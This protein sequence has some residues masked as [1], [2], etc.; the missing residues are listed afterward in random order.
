MSNVKEKF[1]GVFLVDGKLATRATF[2]DFR[3]FGELVVGDY[4]LWDPNR[5]K[6][7][8]AIMKGLKQMPIFP[9]A[10]VLYL[11]LAHAFSA[12]YVAD[13]VGKQGIIYGVEFS[14]RPF[15]EAL[16]I[17]EKYGNIVAIKADA[18]KTELFSWIEKV[19]VVFCD[20]ADTQMTE[21][22]AR[23]CRAFLKPDGFLMLAIKARSID[24]TAPP[25]QIVDAEV[26]K[27]RKEGFDILQV[28][29]LDPFE[30]DHGFLVA[31]M[32]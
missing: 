18:R 32:K 11:G 31:R 29:M 9:G 6:L 21:V 15:T 16:P 27:L 19:D 2:K 8:A 22:A 17:C 4:R 30:K 10:K 20:I 3:P 12:S 28:L 13:I 23:N 1:S 26:E 14:E 25:K 24:V 5:S 7:G